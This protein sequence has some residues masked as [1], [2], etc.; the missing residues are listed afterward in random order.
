MAGVIR[1]LSC[2]A[3]ANAERHVASRGLDQRHGLVA[4]E[5][6]RKLLLEPRREQPLGGILL[7]VHEP[8][9]EVIDF[10]RIP[11]IKRD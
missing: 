7:R 6:P 2:R 11:S 9:R 3:I 8:S 10:V 5:N 1:K 4:A